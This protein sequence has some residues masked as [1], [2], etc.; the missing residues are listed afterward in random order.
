MLYLFLTSTVVQSVD[1]LLLKYRRGDKNTNG[2][3][4]LYRHFEF[5]ISARDA[6]LF[7]INRIQDA[8]MAGVRGFSLEKLAS[9]RMIFSVFD[10]RSTSTR[11]VSRDRYVCMPVAGLTPEHRELMRRV[12]AAGVQGTNSKC[13][14]S[15][16]VKG[17]QTPPTVQVTFS[18]P[19][20]NIFCCC[21]DFSPP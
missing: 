3:T 15:H 4:A 14:V 1:D 19:P 18:K 9:V 20:V 13:E 11:F 5:K 10:S 21:Y 12:T 8:V 16:E 2:R 6:S 7:R 17:D